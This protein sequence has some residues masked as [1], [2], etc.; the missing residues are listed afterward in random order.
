M[1]Y[2]QPNSMCAIST[3]K[4][5]IRNKNTL[6]MQSCTTVFNTGRS[7]GAK[8]QNQVYIAGAAHIDILCTSTENNKLKDISDPKGGF[9]NPL[10]KKCVRC[11]LSK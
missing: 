10:A 7:N 1:V 4:T 6:T 3:H 5:N 11:P 8:E 2:G 9:V